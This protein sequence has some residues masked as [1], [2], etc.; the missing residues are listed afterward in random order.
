MPAC[1]RRLRSGDEYD[2]QQINRSSANARARVTP[3]E[4]ITALPREAQVLVQGG[5]G[6]SRLLAEA[7]RDS[8]RT[9]LQFTGVW[10]PGVNRETY[11]AERGGVVTTFFMTPELAVAGASVRFLPIRYSDILTYLRTQPF[12]ACMTMLAPPDSAGACSFG[13]AV[14]FLAELWPAIP[15]RIAHLNDNVP[16]THGRQGIARA[17]LTHVLE[18]RA[19]VPGPAPDRDDAVA[20]A[21]AAHFSALVADGACLQAGIGKLPGACLRALAGKHALRIH[22][23]ALG[24]WVLDLIAAG[25]LADE[26]IIAGQALG[27][28][29]LMQSIGA[30]RFQFRPVSYTHDHAVLAGLTGLVTVNGAMQVDL[31]GQAYAEASAAGLYSGPGGALDFARGARAGGGLR[32]LV[33][34]ASRI[35]APGA[36]HGPVS[37][38]R[39]DTDIVVTEQGAADLRSCSHDARAQRLVEIAAPERRQ[40]LLKAWRGDK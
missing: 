27:S 10:L 13:P 7:V 9:D 32:V 38:S 16:R 11:G 22:T 23:G 40:A 8:G 33:L 17:A 39:F 12:D 21:I 19:P 3:H 1:A 15:V 26:P 30:P 37:L 14:D 28:E 5:A 4:I 29:R 24:D 34:P 25:A 6:E 35:V 20:D 31:F 18:Q 2:Q 36:G